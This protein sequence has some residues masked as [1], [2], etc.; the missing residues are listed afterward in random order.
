[1][2]RLWEKMIV[3]KST[4]YPK[5]YGNWAGLPKGVEPDYTRCCQEVW[6]R[7]RFSSHH[8]C[9]KPRG[10]GPDGAYCKQH[11]PAVAKARQEA[12]DARSKEKWNEQRY[13]WHGRTFFDAL[14]KIANGYNDARGMASEVIAKFKEGEQ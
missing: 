14:L 13:Q 10:Y 6:S 5:S 7:E 1:M 9:T 2:S 3:E 4:K 8:Q 12:N 11:D